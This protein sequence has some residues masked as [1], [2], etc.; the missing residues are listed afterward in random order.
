VVPLIR[1]SLREGPECDTERLFN[2]VHPANPVS[3]FPWS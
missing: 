3:S 2:P 1:G